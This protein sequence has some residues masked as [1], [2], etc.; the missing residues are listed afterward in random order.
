MILG[1][2]DARNECQIN[3]ALDCRVKPGN[4]AERGGSKA[5]TSAFST[6]LPSPSPVITVLDPVI[7]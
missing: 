7:H 2:V 5:D 4:D 6:D 3:G 1:F